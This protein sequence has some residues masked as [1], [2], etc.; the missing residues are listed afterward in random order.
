MLLRMHV[1]KAHSLD[2]PQMCECA[3]ESLTADLFTASQVEFGKPP[4][5]F[6]RTARKRKETALTAGHLHFYRFLQDLCM[7]SLRTDQGLEAWRHSSH[8]CSSNLLQKVLPSISGQLHNQWN[9]GRCRT[10]QGGRTP[11][12]PKSLPS[13]L[14]RTDDL[15]YPAQGCAW[16][17][18]LR[19][20]GHSQE[21]F[22]CSNAPSVKKKT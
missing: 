17:F 12:L 19:I 6:S 10:R 11:G 13:S 20:L 7:L 3:T 16:I 1:P 9:A 22:T 4:G 18:A 8:R 21:I 5:H 15:A 14:A 2:H